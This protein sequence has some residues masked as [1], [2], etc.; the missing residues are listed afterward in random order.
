MP[1][2]K[3]KNLAILI[4][5]LANAALVCLLIPRQLEKH[6]QEQALR[7]S[8][9]ALC[10]EQDVIL[11]PDC[12]GISLSLY[13]L[14]LNDRSDAEAAALTILLDDDSTTTANWD[15]GV[16]SIKLDGQKSVSDLRSHTKSILK[17]MQF[18]ISSL[19]EPVRRSPGIYDITAMQSV[20]G[21]PVF[22][23]GLTFTYAN[24]CLRDV[25]GSFF[26]GT[27]IR[28]DDTVCCSAAEAVVAFLGARVDLGWVGST[29]TGLEQGY[30][31]A[32]L[33]GL[34]RLLPGWKLST[35]TGCFYVN[36][37]DG[38]VQSAQ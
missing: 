30:L 10:A 19:S 3:L 34:V 5:L 29:I 9:T 28:T 21:V 1:V 17:K 38:T 7:D 13:P 18:Q 20:L 32:D 22:S 12:I 31:P 35:D 16:L 14:D 15:N 25:N 37:V 4:L 33:T 6:A 8:L 24:N 26:T 23:Q 36:G 2:S 27:L 11:Q